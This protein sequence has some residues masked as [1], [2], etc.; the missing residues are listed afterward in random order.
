M[1]ARVGAGEAVG[2]GERDLRTRER[3]LA[4]LGIDHPGNRERGI[5]GTARRVDQVV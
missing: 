2:G 5:L 3:R 1:A 4:A